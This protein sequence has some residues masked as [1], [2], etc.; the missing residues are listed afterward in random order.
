MQS[1][2]SFWRLIGSPPPLVI[3]T[4]VTASAL[5]SALKFVHIDWTQAKGSLIRLGD[6]P[7]ML[8]ALRFGGPEGSPGRAHVSKLAPPYKN[9][10][11]PLLLKLIMPSVLLSII[12]IITI[13]SIPFFLLLINNTWI[14]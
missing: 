13:I 6:L 9:K 2:S 1:S 10:Y 4:I 3:K 11:V 8:G 7:A 12:D 5:A 14:Y